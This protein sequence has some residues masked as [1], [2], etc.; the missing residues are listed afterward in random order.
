MKIYRVIPEAFVVA[1]DEVDATAR[2][3]ATQPLLRQVGMEPNGV[4]AI[5]V[6][7]SDLRFMPQ[8]AIRLL[9]QAT[10]AEYGPA[11]SIAEL[12]ELHLAVLATNGGLISEVEDELATVRKT[13][14]YIPRRWAR[15]R[16]RHALERA[17]RPIQE[18]PS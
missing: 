17:T 6:P 15:E 18:V 2:G 16:I 5:E 4:R 9:E 14:G 11:A 12:Q 1:V 13:F 7:D 8:R 10:K 3:R